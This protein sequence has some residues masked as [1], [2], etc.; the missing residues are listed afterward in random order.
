MP[1]TIRPEDG[2]PDPPW[3]M[4]DEL[5]AQVQ[6]LLPPEKAKGPG[7]PGGRASVDPRRTM[8]AIFYILRT[9]EQ[10]N[11]LPR[12]LGSDATAHRYFQKWVQAGVF[13]RLWRLGLEQYDVLKGIQ[14][15]WQA[16]DGAIT[17]A[18]LAVRRL[19]PTPRT[20]P[21][22]APNARS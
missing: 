18:P 20:G 2:K 15:D 4:P 6:P 3:L 1:A 5:W 16:M 8:D 7:T 12:S 10:W 11:A 14:W 9:G 22:T 13:E 19:A 21:R 17:K